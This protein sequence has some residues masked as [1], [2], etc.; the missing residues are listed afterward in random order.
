MEDSERQKRS[1]RKRYLLSSI[2]YLLVLLAPGCAGRREPPAQLAPASVL[3]ASPAVFVPMRPG[4]SGVPTLLA[5]VGSA[6]RPGAP[7]MG[8]AGLALMILDTGAS[9]VV[10]TQELASRTG[11]PVRPSRLYGSDATGS[12]RRAAGAARVSRLCLGGPRPGAATTAETSAADPNVACFGAFDAYVTDLSHLARIP[13]TRVDGIVGLPLFRD[14]LLTID[15]PHAALRV[16]RGELPPPDGRDVL[17]I[18]FGAGGRALIPLNLGGRELWAHL[19]SGFSGGLVVPDRAVADFPGAEAAVS[20]G[21]KFNFVHG[22]SGRARTARLTDDLRLGRHVIRRPVVSVGL[23][24]EPTLGT[25][26]LRHFAVTIDQKNRR[27]RF[28]RT[29]PS[30]IEV[31]PVY[32][33]GFEA[34]PSTG[35]VKYVMPDSG[36]QRAGMRVGDRVTA[37]EGVPFD[38]YV[39][40]GGTPS[41]AKPG[42]VGV[43]VERDGKLLKL[44]VPLTV[45]V[46]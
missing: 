24:Q 15:Y 46:P 8:S 18:R 33:A 1:G 26:Y 21:D 30:P 16:E 44:S 3:L 2:L 29:E 6:E 31:P 11:L 28:A 4:S 19:D 12:V 34:D 9:F 14:V 23:G 32:R 41:L 40:Q 36:A 10:V 27:V 5:A 20:A 25:E 43:Q 39:R 37:V 7:G 35:T 38:R 13:G 45:V 17:P 42:Y 22:G